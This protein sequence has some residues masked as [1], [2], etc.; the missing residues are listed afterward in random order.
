MIVF[1]VVSNLNELVNHSDLSIMF[2]SIKLPDFYNFV[3]KDSNYNF[4][5][6]FGEYYNIEC[7]NSDN[8][9][10]K[11]LHP[12]LWLEEKNYMEQIKKI[13]TSLDQ[14]IYLM[15][16]INEMYKEEINLDDIPF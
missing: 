5:L 3:Y 4:I 13:N 16:V 11:L 2:K 8:N 9:T 6:D 14:M 1:K 10:F 15:N 7:Y 12:E